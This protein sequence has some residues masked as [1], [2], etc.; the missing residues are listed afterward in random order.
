MAKR[1]RSKRGAGWFDN[2][3]W[4]SASFNSRTYMMWLD[5]AQSL[6][7]NRFKWLNLPSGCDERYLEIQLLTRGM[8]SIAH[9][10][11]MPD[12]WQSLEANPTGLISPYGLP[13]NWQARGANGDM[14]G[15]T[16]ESGALCFDTQSR[17]NVWNGI[18]L[19]CRKLTHIARTDDINLS[20]QQTPWFLTC[21][22]EKR[23]E[24]INIYKMIA[25]GEP[26]ILGNDSLR[27][28]ID[29][30]AI[31]T[32]VEFLG[33]KLDT[34][35]NNQLTQLYQYLGIE[36]L[37]F[38]KGERMIESEAEGNRKP[39]TTRLL[40]FLNARRECA[41]Y[42]NERFGFDI[43]VVFNDDIESYNWRVDEMEVIEDA[44]LL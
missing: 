35:R 27:G 11:D 7:L 22:E 38:Q 24:L 31:N 44:K 36:H 17:S 5:Y 19:I 20:H 10:P 18:E 23:Q 30:T 29:I 14:Y 26:A 2:T 15:A 3:Y 6:A 9:K 42:L 13:L 12:I 40:D 41:E 43:E 16:W 1:N 8:A 39:T 34:K 28:L 4:Q 37:A 21:P 33:D 25:G 32:S